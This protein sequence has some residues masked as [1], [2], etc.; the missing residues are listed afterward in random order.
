M[1]LVIALGKGGG[2]SKLSRQSRPR[3]LRC[4]RRGMRRRCGARQ[5]RRICFI[6]VAALAFA[7]PA[8]ML[9]VVACLCT[10]TDRI[11]WAS[12]IVT[13]KTLLAMGVFHGWQEGQQQGWVMGLALCIV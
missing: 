12:N 13:H 2:T 9:V 1:R 7:G 10:L 4:P 3:R 6:W 8:T 11:L 5:V